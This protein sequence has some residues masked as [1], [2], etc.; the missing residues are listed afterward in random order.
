MFS[1]QYGLKKEDNLFDQF[2]STSLYNTPL[3]RSEEPR[4]YLN[5]IG[6]II[7]F[8]AVVNTLIL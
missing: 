3:R 1:I 4:K 2:F 5:R 8:N 7:L 6:H